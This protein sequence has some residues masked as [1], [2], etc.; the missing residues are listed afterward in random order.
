MSI[1]GGIFAEYMDSYDLHVK[2]GQAMVAFSAVTLIASVVQ[3]YRYYKKAPLPYYTLSGLGAFTY[4]IGSSIVGS[5]DQQSGTLDEMVPK[6]F[7][8]YFFGSIFPPILWTL[9]FYVYQAMLP[10]GQGEKILYGYVNTKLWGTAFGYLWAFII[11]ICA[12]GFVGTAG[13]LFNS[14][15]MSYNMIQQALNAIRTAQFVNFGLWAFIALYA[16]QHYI[17]YD[18]MR[19]ILRSFYVFSVL[20]FFV[21]IGRTVVTSNVGDQSA[22]IAV[23]AVYFVFA[24]LFGLAALGV[25]LAFGHTW[26]PEKDTENPVL[27]TTVQNIQPAAEQQHQPTNPSSATVGD[28]TEVNE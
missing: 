2:S 7:A 15:S 17:S 4:L 3:G 24:E 21:V 23:E 1:F 13:T 12:I 27:P 10:V 9:V 14:T 25:V 19:P 26:Q 6:A 5:L 28:K 20:A 8:S 18:Y 16:Y 22:A 11:F